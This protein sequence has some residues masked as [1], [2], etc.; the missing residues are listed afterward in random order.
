MAGILWRTNGFAA[1]RFFGVDGKRRTVSLG[2]CSERIAAEVA[3]HVSELEQASKHNVAVEAETRKWLTGTATTLLQ[4]LVKAGLADARDTGAPTKLGPFIDH[5]ISRR[6][7]AKETSRDVWRRARR[8]LLEFFA[9]ELPLSLVTSGQAKGFRQFLMVERE[10]ADATVRKMCSVA[11]QFFADAVDRKLIESNPFQHR[12]IP[13]ASVA[14]VQKAFITREDAQKVLDACPN[15]QWRLIFALSRFG[16]LRCPSE[17]LALRW[18]DVDW[19]QG[20]FTVRSSKTEHH[21]GKASRVVPIFPELRPYL[22]ECFDPE[23]VHVITRYRLSNAN[24]RTHLCRIIAKAGLEPWPKLFNALRSTRET[25][26]EEE[27]PS[28]V[29]CAWLGN[30]PRVAQK[31][32]LQVTDDHFRRAGEMVRA[33]QAHQQSTRRGSQGAAEPSISRRKSQGAA[34]SKRRVD[35]TGLE[36]VTSSV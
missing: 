15:A 28:H 17:H 11:G 31:H 36:P 30:S 29:V 16:G 9:A 5:Y 19:E 27:F 7:D 1:V 18:A 23:A 21:A 32:Y 6:K 13:T 22:E 4:E 34:L 14:G 33:P 8:L 3:K 10:L 12:D 35:A 26:L 25:E 2:K 20:R 24:L